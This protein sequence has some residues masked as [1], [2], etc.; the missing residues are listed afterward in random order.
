[1]LYALLLLNYVRRLTGAAMFLI[2]SISSLLHETAWGYNCATAYVD[3]A[4]E[5]G[6]CMSESKLAKERLA[7]VTREVRSVCVEL[8]IDATHIKVEIAAQAEP[9]LFHRRLRGG[10]ILVNYLIAERI[11]A[12]SAHAQPHARYINPD[13][14]ESDRYMERQLLLEQP[15][16]EQA[17]AG[18]AIDGWALDHEEWRFMLACELQKAE[19]SCC[20]E[21]SIR[22]ASW[23]GI[24]G[25]GAVT[26][27]SWCCS[28]HLALQATAE[29]IVWVGYDKILRPL[30]S[31]WRT[32]QKDARG[33]AVSISGAERLLKRLQILERYRDTERFATADT[34]KIPAG[35]RL[36]ALAKNRP[37]QD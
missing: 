34:V 18:V 31:R 19:D 30:I 4:D 12:L 26:S 1:M 35:E 36:A 15:S 24:I 9:L 11:E 21:L 2:N 6:C 10:T 5:Y 33:A 23:Y 13:R 37:H 29:A 14:W 20:E 3:I 8:Q 27:L 28:C 17:P 16:E 32:K 7:A 25:M 22:T